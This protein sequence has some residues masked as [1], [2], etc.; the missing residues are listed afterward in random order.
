M[1]AGDP[2]PAV[3]LPLH[4]VWLAADILDDGDNRVVRPGLGKL[5]LARA[6]GAVPVAAAIG[7]RIAVED[8]PGPVGVDADV[9]LRGPVRAAAAL[10]VFPGRASSRGRVEAV[11]ATGAGALLTVRVRTGRVLAVRIGAG[12][13][14]GSGLGAGSGPRRGARRRAGRDAAAGHHPRAQLAGPRVHPRRPRVR[15]AP[16][17]AGSYA[18]RRFRPLTQALPGSARCRRR[19][20]RRT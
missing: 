8:V 2:P 19:Q 6:P 7:I 1:V 16:A 9:A 12:C 10:P 14:A 17:R 5:C 15:C 18:H 13:P 4:V 3:R 11:V 20:H